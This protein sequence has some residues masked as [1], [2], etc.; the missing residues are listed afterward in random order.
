MESK[1]VGTKEEHDVIFQINDM[2]QFMEECHK[3]WLE[4]LDNQ[5]SKF[6]ELNFFTTD[7]IVFLRNELAKITN[8]QAT[9]PVSKYVYPM[10]HVLKQECSESDIKDA[11]HAAFQSLEV[12]YLLSVSI[13]I[14]I[15][16]NSDCITTWW[17][18]IL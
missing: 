12:V 11:I 1:L 6:A 5:R 8:K 2:C 10:L 13:F 17:Q 3:D 7:Q 15:L 9:D 16:Y 18:L 4:Y 14:Q